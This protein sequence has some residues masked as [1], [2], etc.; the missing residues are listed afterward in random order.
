MLRII[1]K[2]AKDLQAGDILYFNSGEVM[3]FA[4]TAVNPKAN[5][6]IGI[7]YGDGH[8]IIRDRFDQVS[9]VAAKSDSEL[10]YE[11]VSTAYTRNMELKAQQIR[12][13]QK[14]QR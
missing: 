12:N 9:V 8:Y 6:M 4:I 14:H 10:L 11:S 2:Q 7:S 3:G 5:E 13:D 1:Q